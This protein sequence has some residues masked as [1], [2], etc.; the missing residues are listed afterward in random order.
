MSEPHDRQTLH[1]VILNTGV[2]VLTW[3]SRRKKLM[4][5]AGDVVSTL[6]APQLPPTT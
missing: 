5:L 1:T 6:M 2:T 4:R 3:L